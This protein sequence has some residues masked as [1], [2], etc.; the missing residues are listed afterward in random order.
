MINP[1]AELFKWG[2]IDGRPI[3]MDAFVQAFVDYPQQTGYS[4]PDTIGYSQKDKTIFII[5]YK[6]LREAGERLF[7]KYILEEKELKKH[8][9]AWLRVVQELKEIERKVNGGLE[10]YPNKKLKELYCSWNKIHLRFWLEG[11]LP[12]FSNWGGEQLLKRKIL[13]FNKIHFIE[14]FEKT[15]A[16][17]ELSFFQKEELEFLGIKLTQNQEAL[18]KKHQQKYYWLR[19]SYGFTKVLS[20]DYFQE[21]LDKISPKEAKKKIKEINHYPKKVKEEKEKLIKKYSLSPEIVEIAHKLAYC[22][23]WQDHRKQ[24]IFIAN[25]INS[26]FMKEISRR[27]GIPFKELCYYLSGEVEEL[28]KSGKKISAKER[29]KGFITYYHENDGIELFVGEKARQRVRP[30]LEV[31]VDPH[32]KEFSG[33]VVSQGKNPLVQ[34]RVRIILT[35][36]TVRKMNPG[37][38][39]VAPMT[40]PD[41][42][43]AMRKAS[44]II[45]DEGSMTCHAAIVSRELNLPCIVS[46]RIATKILKD[47]DLVEVDANKGTIKLLK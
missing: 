10:K 7:T 22:V 45:T 6:P 1:R 17:E 37:E 15:S 18:L 3:Y 31:K 30:Y 13:Q 26:S 5:E 24:F 32:L 23:W 14:I 42:I 29:F 41:F 20:G 47:G 25:H 27:S 38:I 9:Q 36:R 21:E 43:V 40:S 28:L 33:L 16:P 8:Y 46:T 2:P 39:L 19:N 11:F 35:P 4:W 34:G 12:E 44:A